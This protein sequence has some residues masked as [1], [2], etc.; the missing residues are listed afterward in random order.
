MDRSGV[1]RSCDLLAPALSGK[2]W[3]HA[4]CPD[5]RSSNVTFILSYDLW[6]DLKAVNDKHDRPLADPSAAHEQIADSSDDSKH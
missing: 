3:L 6:S 2:K 4:G 5:S 1:L